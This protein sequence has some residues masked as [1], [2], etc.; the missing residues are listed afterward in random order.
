MNRVLFCVFGFLL[1]AGSLH[2]SS[3]SMLLKALARNAGREA[4][5]QATEQM[6]K[7]VGRE[8]VERTGQK[9]VKQGGEE[10]LEQTTDLVARH[11]VDVLRAVDN[12][13]DS[14][15]VLSSLKALPADEVAKASSRLAAGASGKELAELTGKY[16]VAALRAEAKHPGIGVVF[17]KALGADGAQLA[18]QLTSRQATQIGRYADEIGKLP[19]T[20]RRSLVTLIGDQ[21]DRFAKF[22]AR[23]T[24][25]NP[26]KVLFTTSSTALLLSNAERIL[27]GDTI[28]F[29]AD[30]NPTLV[31]KPGLV[32]RAGQAVGEV[33]V[34]P[35]S[36]L[37]NYVVIIIAG[38]IGLVAVSKVIKIIRADHSA[39]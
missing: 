27:G 36:R 8:F 17:T 22:V 33:V 11:G 21:A 14:K 12:T 1:S 3:A 18:T 19:A 34:E 6:A 24:E 9:I 37:L 2:A 35:A 32:G 30:G 39:P 38:F 5:S 25:Q 7:Q 29:D 4:T 13:P 16:G 31:S 10:A 28:V 26:G 20:Q 23:F 15:L